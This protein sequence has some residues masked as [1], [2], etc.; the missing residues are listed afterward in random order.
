VQ[1]AWE[2]YDSIAVTRFS[3]SVYDHAAGGYLSAKTY[4]DRTPR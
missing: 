2:T 3:I 1:R 4:Y